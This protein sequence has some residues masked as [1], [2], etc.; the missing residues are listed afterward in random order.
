VLARVLNQCRVRGSQRDMKTGTKN[1][2]KISTKIG[3][4]SGIM[5]MSR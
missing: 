2:T 3:M 4:K 5:M 1:L